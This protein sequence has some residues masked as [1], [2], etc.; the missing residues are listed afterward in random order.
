MGRQFI[1]PTHFGPYRS[2]RYSWVAHRRLRP[3]ALA[4]PE[5]DPLIDFSQ[6]TIAAPA[7]LG[8]S[9]RRRP[10]NLHREI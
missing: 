1:L 6:R 7:D 2:A 3:L 8:K 5:N 10:L 4:D 9:G